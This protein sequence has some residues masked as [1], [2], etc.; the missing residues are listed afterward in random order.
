[1][2][3]FKL[4]LNEGDAL[5]CGVVDGEILTYPGYDEIEVVVIRPFLLNSGEAV[6]APEIDFVPAPITFD[7][8]CNGK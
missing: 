7:E 3:K 2:A 1:M 5:H 4:Y 6:I 8:G